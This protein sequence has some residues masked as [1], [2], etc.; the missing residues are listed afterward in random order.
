M[1]CMF[2]ATPAIL[3]ELQP[4]GIVSSILLGRV[5][6]LFAVVTLKRNHRADILLLGSHL[7][8]YFLVIPGSW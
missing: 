8:P 1:L 5:I 4:I 6:P 3:I 2:L 7:L